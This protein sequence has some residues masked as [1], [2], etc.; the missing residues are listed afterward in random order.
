MIFG[1]IF[2]SMLHD[3]KETL[4]R[5]NDMEREYIEIMSDTIQE[6]FGD[7]EFDELCGRFG[8]KI[9]YLGTQPNRKKLV[10]ELITRKFD[11]HNRRFL[12]AILPKLLQRCEERILNCTWEVNI[13]DEQM[14]PQLKKLQNF[15]SGKKESVTQTQSV[16]RFFTTKE[17]LINFFS[18]SKTV[19]MI[20]DTQIGKT[21]FDC[22]QKVQTP[23]RLLTRQTLQ[24]MADNVGGYLAEF[25]K[26]GREIETRRHLKLNDRFIIFNG[27][28]W[29]ASCS[30]VDAGK[31]TLSIIECVDTQAVV[32]KDIGRKWRE[33]KV[34]LN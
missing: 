14:L 21:T 13:F 18:K 2:A 9:E 10:T 31:A 6:Y 29:L 28:C 24:D 15:I 1:I 4:E 5:R 34:Y 17:Q 26:N 3:Y 19:L 27:H 25:R 12:E 22:I 8:L 30:L 23:I 7:Y 16:N 20:V 32:V 11:D 33:A